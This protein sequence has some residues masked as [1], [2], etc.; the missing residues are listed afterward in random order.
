M[1]KGRPDN[2]LH[3][4]GEIGDQRVKEI[5]LRR[6]REFEK[7]PRERADRYGRDMWPTC[8]SCRSWVF[9]DRRGWHGPAIESIK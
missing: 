8:C 4:L 7:L 1:S 9:D 3:H 2:A 6:S 5:G